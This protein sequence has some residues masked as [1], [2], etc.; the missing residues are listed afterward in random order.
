VKAEA[1]F[2]IGQ[3]AA[4]RFWNAVIRVNSRRCDCVAQL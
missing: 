4:H 1:E 3:H 2:V